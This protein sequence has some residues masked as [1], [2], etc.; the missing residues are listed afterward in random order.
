M[1]GTYDAQSH[2]S[3]KDDLVMESEIKEL[4]VLTANKSNNY[5]PLSIH[6]K[7]F[8]NLVYNIN[9]IYFLSYF[10]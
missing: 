6:T 2:G 9:K 10:K 4:G 8:P 1:F 7:I 3:P 5:K